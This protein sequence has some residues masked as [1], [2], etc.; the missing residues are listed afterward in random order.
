[1]FEN[2]E[3]FLQKFVKMF[4]QYYKYQENEKYLMFSQCEK[5]I[6]FQNG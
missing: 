2:F 6:L 1:M 4:G 3:K 5:Y